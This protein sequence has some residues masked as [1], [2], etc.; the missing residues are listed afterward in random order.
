ME[1]IRKNR[2]E[3]R[4][5][6]TL[7]RGSPWG[8]RTAPPG[9]PPAEVLPLWVGA[10]PGAPPAITPSPDGG[11]WRSIPPGPARARPPLAHSGGSNAWPRYEGMLQALNGIP[12]QS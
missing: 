1:G 12:G 9:A 10:P 3:W 6:T 7:G 11:Q 8:A 5:G 4:H 2:A